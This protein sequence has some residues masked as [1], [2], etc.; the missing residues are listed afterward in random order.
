MYPHKKALILVRLIVKLYDQRIYILVIPLDTCPP[1]SF[2]RASL[3]RPLFSG[4][5]LY[6][7]LVTFLADQLNYRSSIY[8]E[9]VPDES[10]IVL[11][12]H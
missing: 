12:C 11:P 9:R 4:S 7:E 2:Q 8:T 10:V 6:F 5:P 1:N 3:C